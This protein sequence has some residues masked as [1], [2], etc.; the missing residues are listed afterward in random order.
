[1]PDETFQEF[2]SKP[3][4]IKSR[5]VSATAVASTYVETPLDHPDWT[6]QAGVGGWFARAKKGA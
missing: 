2:P 4:E 1:M 3:V 6:F 5:E